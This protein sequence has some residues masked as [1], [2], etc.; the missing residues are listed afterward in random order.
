MKNLTAMT[1]AASI[2][3]L[4]AGA[5]G[6]QVPVADIDSHS[7]VE[8]T[9]T[10]TEIRQST[11]ASKTDADADRG[12]VVTDEIPATEEQHRSSRHLTS[13]FYAAD[14]IGHKVQNRRSDKG[15]GEVSNLVIDK[16][17]KVVAILVNREAANNAGK[18]DV[19]IGWEQMDRVVADGEIT[20]F[21]DMDETALEALPEYA[22]I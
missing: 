12:A 18:R 14:L 7:T 9:T 2:S 19:A 16:D 8:S 5:A 13:G 15:V 11:V 6:A 20:L 10:R 21:I 3:M 1:L 22:H 4:L 17:G